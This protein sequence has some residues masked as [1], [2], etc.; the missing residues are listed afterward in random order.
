MAD[1]V[2][3]AALLIGTSA[4]RSRHYPP[5]PA[6]ANSL[7]EMQRLLVDPALCGWPQDRVHLV[8]NPS[9]K[10]ENPLF[11]LRRIAES[12]SDVLLV[13][14]VGHG[15]IG[16]RGQ[17]YLTLT[18]TEERD[19]DL[20]GIDYAKVR[21]VLYDS[22]A[23]FKIVIL[24]CCYSGRA[25]ESLAAEVADITD[26]RGTYVL[27]ASDSTAHVVPF[28]RQWDTATSFTEE[29][30][31]TVRAGVPGGPP[32]LSLAAL[33]PHLRQRL[34]AR[35]LPSPNQRNVD[36]ADQ[37]G[38]TRNTA[39]VSVPAPLPAFSLAYPAEQSVGRAVVPERREASRTQILP[40]YVVC[41]ASAAMADE[42]IETIGNA[43]AELYLEIGSSPI[44]AAKT[45]ISLI[46][47]SDTA[48][49]VMPLTDVQTFP[50]F[51]ALRA[52]G[53]TRYE[54]VFELLRETIATNDTA[55]KADGYSTFRPAVF[56]VTG[57]RPTDFD[58]WQASYARL[59]DPRGIR[60]NILAFGFG[61]ADP[62]TV[63]QVAT[64]RG[65]VADVVSLAEAVRDY[66]SSLIRSVVSSGAG[67]SDGYSGV[68]LIL[69]DSTP[70]YT[71]I[72]FDAI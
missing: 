41:E 22:A 37:F 26:I 20:T 66:A 24:D 38:F 56:F 35:G 14:F 15:T 70:G 6:A 53:G 57:G 8:E 67:N 63:L 42:P 29:L 16:R 72:D 13:Y 58:R 30:A 64:V 7:I 44:L 25:I 11:L 54:P 45:R 59:V 61:D 27:T 36:Q 68:R 51:P 3:S 43:F 65:F 47:F 9:W 49:V 55:L 32:T 34:H 10:T 40:L 46:T 19:E 28:D 62:A 4:Y 69:P 52:R 2:R 31:A 39:Y 50:T 18:D 17:L 21:E 33:Y 60:P 23:H 1:L 12:T 71:A 48:E 5:L